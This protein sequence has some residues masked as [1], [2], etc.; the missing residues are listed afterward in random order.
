MIAP[1]LP[2]PVI[3]RDL[4]RKVAQWD[5]GQFTPTV[6]YDLEGTPCET[7]IQEGRACV[8]SD[9]LSELFPHAVGFQSYIGIP[10]FD[11]DRNVI[12]HLV[13]VDPQPF[14]EEFPIDLIYSLF[15]VRASLEFE[16]RYLLRR[17]AA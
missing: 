11:G 1:A 5:A 7:V 4:V 6:E 14:R 12:G 10:M 13:A 8:Y 17:V 2:R 3:S 15:A 9:R 16:R